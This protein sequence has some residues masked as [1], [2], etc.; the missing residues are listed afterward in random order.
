[1]ATIGLSKPFYAIYSANGETVS[2][3]GGGVLGKAVELSM[4]LE[5]GEANIL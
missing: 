2:Y 1:M 4:E 3:T 5:G